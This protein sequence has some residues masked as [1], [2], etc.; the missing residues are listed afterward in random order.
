[1]GPWQLKQHFEFTMTTRASRPQPLL[2][3][4]GE[5]RVSRRLVLVGEMSATLLPEPWNGK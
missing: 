2:V 1:M 5:N 3:P 4:G